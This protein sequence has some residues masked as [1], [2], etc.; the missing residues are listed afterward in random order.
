MIAFFVL[1]W[2][3]LFVLLVCVLLVVV[4]TREAVER[5]AEPPAEPTDRTV[6]LLAGDQP[7]TDHWQETACGEWTCPAYLAAADSPEVGVW[8]RSDGTLPRLTCDECETRVR[9]VIAEHFGTGDG[10]TERHREAE[11]V[12]E[13]ALDAICGKEGGAQ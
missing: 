1:G 10:R 4:E 11:H 8:R 13:D 12:G 2:A 3:L 6:H 9:E 7:I 5:P